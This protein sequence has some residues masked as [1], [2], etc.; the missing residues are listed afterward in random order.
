MAVVRIEKSEIGFAC[1]ADDTILSAGLR[2][3]YGLQYECNAGGCGACKARLVEGR[4]ATLWPESPAWTDADRRRGRIL[5]CQSVPE[6]DC[7]IA[8]QID[9][10]CKP[11]I[12]PVRRSAVIQE[13]VPLTHDLF[14]VDI[15]T[16]GPSAFLPGQFA[17]LTL[18]GAVRRAYSMAGLPDPDG[19]WTF[20]IRDVPG[21]AASAALFGRDSRKLRVMIDAPYGE[22]Y[23]RDTARDILC[24]AGGSGLAPMLSI[25]RAFAGDAAFEARNLTFLYGG[26][27]VRDLGHGRLLDSIAALTP[28]IRCMMSVSEPDA[29]DPSWSGQR[30][31]VHELLGEIPGVCLHDLDHYVAGPPAMID[32]VIRTLE[33]VH[34]VPPSQIHF[35]RFF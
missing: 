7:V 17:I 31:F 5:L 27:R 19:R 16:T 9:A 21:G 20:V 6:T 29:D 14:E 34:A 8:V 18:P 30:G 28:R 4:V 25:A 35:D 10:A 32:A 26:R 22:A 3:G 11:R 15:A 33:D 13:I 23:L 24:I 1:G 12:P 2:A